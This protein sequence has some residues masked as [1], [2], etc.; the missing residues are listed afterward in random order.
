LSY[1]TVKVAHLLQVH[2][3]SALA[4]GLQVDSFLALATFLPDREF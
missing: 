1:P 4:D 2:L 3:P